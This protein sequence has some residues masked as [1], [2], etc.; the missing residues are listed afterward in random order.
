MARRRCLMRS[1]FYIQYNG[2]SYD[3]TLTFPS[4]D[5]TGGTVEIDVISYRPWNVQSKPAWVTM[6]VEGG[7]RGKTHVTLTIE[8]NID[9]PR[10]GSITIGPNTG[11]YSIIMYVNEGEAAKHFFVGNTIPEATTTACTYRNLIESG[12]TSQHYVYYETNFTPAEMNTLTFEYDSEV[13]TAVSFDTGQTKIL[14]NLSANK[15]EEVKYFY[16]NTDSAT[17]AE[18]SI[19]CNSES[20][21]LTCFTNYAPDEIMPL[22]NVEGNWAS[23]TLHLMGESVVGITLSSSINYS[24]S[25]RTC[26]ISIKDNTTNTVV[27]THTITQLGQPY[28]YVD[29]VPEVEPNKRLVQYT[30]DAND[31]DEH[32]VYY[33]T[34]YSQEEIT[35][36]TFV[37]T[38]DTDM[39]NDI[40]FDLNEGII[41]FTLNENE[42]DKYIYVGTEI[43]ETNYS[44]ATYGRVISKTD[45]SQ[46]TA[47]MES[48]I[49]K[50][51]INQVTITTP[52]FLSAQI[53]SQ[54]YIMG[55]PCDALKFNFTS[56]N[57]TG[58]ERTGTITLRYSGEDMAILTVKQSAS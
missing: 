40:H 6:S 23:A 52:S 34:N 26:V 53:L 11:K 24:I 17:T 46:Q 21:N 43:N 45:T 5:A 2:A 54:D 18:T 36:F 22:V 50:A 10:S 39:V 7:K 14:F 58:A 31:T 44:A 25:G 49:D 4:F 28:F 9:S 48:T 56:A 38:G 55:A 29:T 1:Y 20:S 27:A 3:E 16:W 37:P 13:V 57:N 47:W 41:K 33:D 51:K 30:F 19:S 12:D 42:T 35:A 8:P 15:D 32:V